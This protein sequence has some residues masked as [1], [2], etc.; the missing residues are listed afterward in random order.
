MRYEWDRR[1]ADA[2]LLKHRIAFDKVKNFVWEAA[3]VYLDTRKDYLELRWIALSMLE[4]RL[5]VLVYTWRAGSIRV[6]S[7]R[8]AN[9]R[10]LRS[11][12]SA[13]EET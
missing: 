10:E 6:L 13:K 5:H 12:F 8:K 3:V 2:N 9:D 11:Y 1:K 7:L 4:E